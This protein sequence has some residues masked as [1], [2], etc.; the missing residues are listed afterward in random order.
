MRQI[1][2]FSLIGLHAKL[3]Q[4]CP[5][6]CDPMDCSPPG[7]SVRGIVQ[8][9]ILEW[10]AMPSSRGFFQP[11]DQTCISYISCL[12]RRV[13]YHLHHL[14]SCQKHSFPDWV[15]NPGHSGQI[16]ATGPTGNCEIALQ[17]NT[18]VIMYLTV[19]RALCARHSVGRRLWYGML[20][21]ISCCLAACSKVVESNVSHVIMTVTSREG[22]TLVHIGPE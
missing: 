6:L 7:S 3:L 10:V 11:R 9:R 8:V 12:G 19:S 14:G 5:T 16:L 20:R 2:N 22:K 18:N 15:L 1:T 17:L 13:L 4:S 21:P